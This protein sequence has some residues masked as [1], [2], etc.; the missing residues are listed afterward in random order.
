MWFN[1]ANNSVNTF[2]STVFYN[3]RKI[4]V[5]LKVRL[6]QSTQL[7]YPLKRRSPGYLSENKI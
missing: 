4:K 5:F 1:N 6:C 3:E 2:I 7:V